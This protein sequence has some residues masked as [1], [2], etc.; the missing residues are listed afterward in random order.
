MEKDIAIREVKNRTAD[1]IARLVRIWE[2]AARTTHLFLSEREIAEIKRRVPQALRAVPH[3]FVAETGGSPTGFAGVDGRRL[4]M[5]FV[6]AEN[7][8]AGI[9]KRLLQ[10]TEENLDADELTVNEQNPQTIG[11]YERMGYE[12]Y[13]R[14]DADEQGAPYP[15][16]YMKKRRGGNG[17]Q[18]NTPTLTTA[19]LVL[20]K[21]TE[22]DIN[23]L[24][25]LLN[26]EEVNKFLP[27]YPLKT[28]DEAKK[29]YEERYA[30][31]Y[32][33][34]QAY[35]YA[36]CLKEDDRPIG[37][38]N[39]GMSEAHDLGYGLRKEFW[40]KG[41]ATEAARAVIAQLKRDGVPY[42]TAT[43]DANN[44][45]SGGVMRNLGM[46]YRYSYEEQ[47]QPKNILVTFRMYQLDLDGKESRVYRA[48]WN[49]SAI[50]FV[51][52]DI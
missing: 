25:S 31:A 27:W 41:I 23:A 26:D 20:R 11:F 16:L 22:R 8:G 36:V 38:V 19:R 18:K 47:W 44:P 24:F 50:H 52:K 6:A 48:Y 43:H 45:R 5:L 9:G 35:A 15:I 49:D 42:V 17:S 37:Y 2:S 21:F 34:S 51:E 40:H 29:F 14:S 28:I 4:E 3:L 46:K 10:Y 12:T 30:C 7:R 13:K 33:Q 1:T 32:A 39:V